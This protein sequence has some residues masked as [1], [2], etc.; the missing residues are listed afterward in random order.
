MYGR[1]AVVRRLHE[2]GCAV[3]RPAPPRPR[4]RRGGWAAAGREP[5]NCARPRPASRTVLTSRR[6]PGGP[7][8][9]TRRTWPRRS[10]GWRATRTSRCGCRG[11][12]RAGADR[13]GS[14]CAGAAGRALAEPATSRCSASRSLRG[15]RDR[16]AAARGPAPPGRPDRQPAQRRRAAAAHHAAARPAPG[17]AAQHRPRLRRHGA[18]RERPGLPAAAGAARGGAHPARWTAGRRWPE[19]AMLE[20]ALPDQPLRHRGRADRR[21]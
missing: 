2:V 9:A 16:L 4:S 12:G 5:R 14:G 21:A 18:V 11:R 10:S 17:A 3:T 6:R 8:C 19:L 13:R 20:A 15:G 7:T 1:D